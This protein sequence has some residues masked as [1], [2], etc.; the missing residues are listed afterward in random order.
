MDGKNRL[1]SNSFHDPRWVDQSDTEQI[2]VIHFEGNV[3]TGIKLLSKT[4]NI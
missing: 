1:N 3:H 4:D 2:I